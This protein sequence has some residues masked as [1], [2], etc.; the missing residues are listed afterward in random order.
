MTG[1]FFR[2]VCRIYYV[3]LWLPKTLMPSEISLKALIFNQ[4]LNLISFI[5][6]KDLVSKL[7][8]LFSVNCYNLESLPKER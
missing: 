7:Q 1:V 2:T 8:H 6:N 5:K 3:L 4:R